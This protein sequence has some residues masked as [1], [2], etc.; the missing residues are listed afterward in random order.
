MN[1]R[2]S[3]I[4]CIFMWYL[5]IELAKQVKTTTLH[6]TYGTTLFEWDRGVF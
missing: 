3:L 1:N 4:Y 2:Y 5:I 6:K